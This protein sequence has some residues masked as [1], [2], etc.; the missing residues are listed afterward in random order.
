MLLEQ[1][2]MQAMVMVVAALA[3]RAMLEL[4]VEVLEDQE[5]V[6]QLEPVVTDYQILYQE[7]LLLMLEEVV[8]HLDSQIDVIPGPVAQE[9]ELQEVMVVV[10]ELEV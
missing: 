8:D 4:I 3:R 6:Q 9:V 2:E 10:E 7:A 5:L 1:R